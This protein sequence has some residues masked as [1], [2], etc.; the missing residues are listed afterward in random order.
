M[1][2]QLAEAQEANKRQGTIK[3]RDDY[4]CFACAAAMATGT[5]L[6]DVYDFVGHD[7]SH[8]VEGSKH[9][10]G[11]AGF[12]LSEIARYLLQ[13]DLLMG[14]LIGPMGKDEPLDMGAIEKDGGLSIWLETRGSPALLVVKPRHLAPPCVHVVYW[15]GECVRDPDPD[16]PDESKLTDY[17]V[18]EWWPLVRIED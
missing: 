9:P 13:H 1:S 11:K 10:R 17:E 6:E 5:E 14:M 4:S 3:Q 16:M 7:G 18:Q 12:T 8:S 2:T 15:D